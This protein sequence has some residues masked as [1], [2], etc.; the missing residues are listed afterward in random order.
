MHRCPESCI[1]TI[2][3]LP[4]LMN[5]FKI[6][7]HKRQTQQLMGVFLLFVPTVSSGVCRPSLLSLPPGM[8]LF[9]KIAWMLEEQLSKGCVFLG[10]K[11][12]VI[13][14]DTKVFFRDTKNC[15]WHFWKVK[16]RKGVFFTQQQEQGA[17]NAGG[18]KPETC[19]QNPQNCSWSIVWSNYSGYQNPTC[20]HPNQRKFHAWWVESFVVLVQQ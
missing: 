9:S 15:S 19:F 8:N 4:R 10:T 16:S 1:C 14:L 3:K 18:A 20:W 11:D 12:Q 5:G 7:S 2:Q 13:F 6:C 17:P